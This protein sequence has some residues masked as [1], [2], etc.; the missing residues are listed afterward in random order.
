MIPCIKYLV[1]LLNNDN[2]FVLNQ[3]GW[4]E[5]DYKSTVKKLVW[6]SLV[7]GNVC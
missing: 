6:M 7:V 1:C 4:H 2:G 3:Q 5:A